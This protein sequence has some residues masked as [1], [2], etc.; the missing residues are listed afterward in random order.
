M[1]WF[2]RVSTWRLLQ[3]TVASWGA[4]VFTVGWLVW[5]PPFD[6]WPRTTVRGQLTDVQATPRDDDPVLYL[7]VSESTLRF[8]L[9]SGIFEKALRSRTPTALVPGASVVLLVP[10]TDIESPIVAPL[11]PTPTAN[12]DA[13]EADGHSVLPLGASKEWNDRNRRVALYLAPLFA[14]GACVCTT[15]VVLRARRRRHQNSPHEP[16]A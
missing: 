14:A 1:K 7:H 15:A 6:D 9:A 16:H 4:T 11:D 8:R 5:V 2:E 12:I 3:G 13:I 10:T